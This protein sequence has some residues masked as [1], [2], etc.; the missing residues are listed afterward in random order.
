MQETLSI[1]LF[2]R[3]QAWQAIKTQAFPFLAAVLQSGQRFILTI[4]P[5]PRTAK[6]NRRYWGNGVLK[7]IAEQAVVSG[8]MYQAEIW[9]EQFKRQFIGVIEL[10]NGQLIGCSS[11]KLT[12]S[13][14]CNFSDQVEAFAAS[15]LGVVFYDLE[16]HK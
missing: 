15:E 12:T 10:P 3:Q 2:N 6:Q 4:K 8:K 11:T 14:F 13:E 9:H 5:R 1:E 7:Q 16:P